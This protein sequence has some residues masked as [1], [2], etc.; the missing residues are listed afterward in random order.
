MNVPV[1]TDAV[2]RRGNFLTQWAMIGLMRLTGWR[3]TGEPYPTVGKFVL[4]IG[5]HTSNWD[6][7][8]GIMAMYA[9]GIRG[10]FLGK[11]TLFKGPLGMIMRFLGGFP[12][13]R[14]NAND[15]V[16]QT[17]DLVKRLDKVTIVLSPE[18]TRKR[19][20]K[21]RSGFYWI[22]T[23]SEIPILPVV[24]DFKRRAIHINP[25]F[26]PT[27][28]MEADIAFLRTYYRAEM[29]FDPGKYVE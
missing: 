17:V 12:V 19:M 28:V 29:A 4:I 1:V 24:F 15:V 11:D 27:G 20:E 10:A 5:P 9:L 16:S 26:Q 8:L 22:A 14:A 7:P 6:F 2:T 25:L 23:K 3:F 13:D 21:W 18:G